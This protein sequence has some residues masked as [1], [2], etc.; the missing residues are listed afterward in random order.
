MALHGLLDSTALTPP[1]DSPIAGP[2]TLNV[3]SR[4]GLVIPQEQEQ[5][6]VSADEQSEYDLLVNNAYNLLYD[7]MPALLKGIAGG[8]DPVT[9]LAQTVANT[10]SRLVNS[11]VRAGKKIADEVVFHAGI[12]IL[13]DLA[14]LAKDSDIHDFKPDELESAT[15]LSV[16][17]Y[18]SLQ[19]DSGN[20]DANA[21]AGD[22]EE[23]QRAEA[24]GTLDQAFPG[25][26]ERFS[27]FQQ[28]PPT[29]GQVPTAGQELPQART[30]L[31]R[32]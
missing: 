25:I 24:D 31:A 29:A 8:G 21:A 3:S 13:E 28:E 27:D 12:E 14:D 16:E 18:R 15:Y 7:N 19:Q 32:R 6:N 1:T 5:P 20:I 22:L 11:A 26:R 9:G 23:L 30:G 17:I 2:S 4:R 10:L